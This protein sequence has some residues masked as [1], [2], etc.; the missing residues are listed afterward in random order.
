MI[1]GRTSSG[2]ANTHKEV[3]IDDISINEIIE[4]DDHHLG[5]FGYAEK[6][7]LQTSKLHFKQA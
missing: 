7:A 4:E 1:L 3:S 6:L 5:D 2:K